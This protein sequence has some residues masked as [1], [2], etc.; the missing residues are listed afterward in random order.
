VNPVDSRSVSKL[1]CALCFAI[2]LLNPI[3]AQQPMEQSDAAVWHE[4][5]TLRSRLSQNTDDHVLAFR[6]AQLEVAMGKPQRAIAVLS[7]N[8]GPDS[9]W[10]ALG[11]RIR[12]EAEYALERFESAAHS[13][14]RALELTEGREAAVL[15]VRAGVAFESAGMA[16]AA[17]ARYA[18]AVDALPELRA[19]LAPRWAG[20]LADTFR[21][22]ELLS[23]AADEVEAIATEVRGRIYANAGDTTRAISVLERADRPG[24]AARLALGFGDSTAARRS[25]YAAVESVDTATIRVG[26]ELTESL[27]PPES[28]DEYLDLAAASRRLG[29]VR[30]ATDFALGA[31]SAG[32]S[33]P[34]TLVYLGDL[35]AA[36]R[37]RLRALTAYRAAAA[38]Q[39]AAAEEAAFKYGRTLLL[40][41]RLNEGMAALSNFVGEFPDHDLVPRAIYGMAD[42]RRRERRYDLSDSLNQIVA[43]RWP[44]NSYASNARMA[45]AVDALNRSDTA[46]AINWY[47]AEVALRGRQRNVAQFRL[48]SIRAASGDTVAARAVWAALARRDSIGY[49]GTIARTA[50]GLPP[51]SVDPNPNI[52]GSNRAMEILETVDLLADSYLSAELDQLLDQLQSD[53][54]RSPRELLD[55]GEGLI[56]RGFVL[57]GIRLGWLASR[58]YTLNHPRVLRIVFPWPYRDLIE[59]TANELDLDPYL[60]AALI[61]QESAF[62]PHAVSRAGAHGLMQLMP[63]TAR[64]VAR[65][66][67]AQWDT[68]LLTIPDA[69]LRLGA[70][71]LE[72]LLRRY[73]DNIIPTLAAYNAGGTPVRR[74]LARYDVNDPIQFVENIPY[75]E[76]RGYLRTVLRNHALYRAL[77][78]ERA[79]GANGS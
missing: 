55:L 2:V 37:A 79:E 59:Q 18:D 25:A 8:A 15:A 35:Y 68:A 7:Q 26:V 44:S 54:S 38:M 4:A 42:R 32:D 45:L 39:G 16:E 75:V 48:G 40:L 19:W 70:T 71:H 52:L 13:F 17:A 47:R 67:G 76:T 33:S 12:G 49:Y 9:L 50:S 41:G 65:K 21:A 57:E 78:P 31:V 72:G 56:E 30:T 51:L 27:F 46:T 73:G 1:S 28:P 64:E 20:V 66:I 58:A 23:E 6:V 22:F 11:F 61:R 34:G 10:E 60:L 24:S 62:T 74:W 69:N 43:E 3:E 5:V 53:R 29:S 63:P 77:Y 14:D 36:R